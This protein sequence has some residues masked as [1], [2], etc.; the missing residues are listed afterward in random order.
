LTIFFFSAG[1]V[2]KRQSLK[3]IDERSEA[4]PLSPKG[5][6][7]LFLGGKKGGSYATPLWGKVNFQQVDYF[8]FI[9][10]AFQAQNGES[11]KL[12]KA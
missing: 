7:G 3:K 2:V 5:L 11:K 12:R 10:F 8:L 4:L 9:S 6:K 1:G